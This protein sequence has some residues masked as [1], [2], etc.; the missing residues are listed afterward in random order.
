MQDKKRNIIIG[1]IVAITVVIAGFL[2]I[3][4]GKL[5]VTPKVIADGIVI[6]KENVDNESRLITTYVDYNELLK[7]YDVDDVVLLTNNSFNEFDYI[8]DFINYERGLEIKEISL[9]IEDGGVRLNYEVNKE[10]KKNNKTI[11]Y[12]IPVEKGILT[13]V[14]IKSRSFTK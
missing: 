10:P 1:S 13:D 11:M 9:V 5:F 7:K 6:N 8:V 2:G 14:I 4:V 12:F 3:M